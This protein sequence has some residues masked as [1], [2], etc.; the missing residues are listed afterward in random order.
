MSA[1]AFDSLCE[2]FGIARSYTDIWGRARA[3]PEASCRA[4]LRAFGVEAPEEPAAAAALAALE[5]QDWQRGLPPVRVVAED[6][7]TLTL[8]VTLPAACAGAPLRW[9]LTTEARETRAG[10]IAL[11]ASAAAATREIEGAH[12]IACEIHLPL[13]T[14]CGYHR[15]ALEAPAGARPWRA[16]SWIIVAPAQ[17]YRP[18]ALAGGGRSWGFTAQIYALRSQRNWG[19]G[20]FTDLLR[21]VERA[22]EAGA[23][24]VGVS[25]LHALFPHNPAHA[26]PYSP[27]SRQFLNTLHLDIEAI[28]ELAE[29]AAARERIAAEAFQAR[30]RGLRASE[31]VRYEEVAQLKAEVL[32]ALHAHFRE[33][34]LAAGDARAREFER[35]REQAG[36]ALRDYAVFEALQ[37]HLHA[38]DPAIWGWPVWPEQY[39]RADSE[40]VTA[41]ARDHEAA[42]EARE[43][44]QWQARAQL[45]R[46]GRRAAELGLA[47]G[48][49]Q[50]L[51]VGVDAAGAET[52][53]ES[54]Q[55]ASGVRLG[56]PPDE[57]NL[58]GQEWGL[59]P[60]RPDR[61]EESGYAPFVRTLRAVMQAAGAIR[62]DH[63]LGLARQFWVPAGASPAEGTYVRFPL[64]DLL[65]VLALESQRHQ[66]LVVGEDLGTVPETIRAGMA[67]FDILSYRL[68]YFSK[69]EDGAFLAPGDYPERALVCA[70]TH[71]LPTLAGYWAGTDIELRRSLGLFPDPGEHENQVVG[72]AE[73]RARLLLALQREGLLPAD[74]EPDVLHFPEMTPALAAAIHRYLARS[75]CRVLTIQLEDLLG[76]RDQVNLPG[77]VDAYPNWRLKLPLDLEA[78][79]EAE[80]VHTLLA[81][82]RAERGSA[83]AAPPPEPAPAAPPRAVIPRATYRLQLHAGF[84]FEAARALVPYL[85]AL[86]VSHLYSSPCL[87]ARPGSR[88]GYDICD[89]ASLNAELGGN[90]GFD[91][92]AEAVTGRGMGLVLDLVPNHMGVMGAD[93]AWWLDVLE[94]GPASRYAEYFDIDWSPLKDELRGKVLVPVLGRLYGEVLDAGELALRL[95][96]GTGTLSVDYYE[97]RFPVDPRSYPVVLDRHIHL[98]EA[99]LGP[100]HPTLLAFQSLLTAFANLPPREATGETAVAERARDAV[101]HKG[102]LAAL[103][104]EQPDV[105]AYLDDCLRQVNGGPDYP[106]DHALLHLLLEQQAYRLAYWRVAADAINYR[107]FFDIND[108]AALRMEREAVFEDTHALVLRLIAEGKVAGLR[109]DHPDGLYDPKAYCAGVQARVAA[110]AGTDAKDA[111]APSIYLVVEKILARDEALPAN[112][113]VHGTTGYEF[114]ATAGGVLLDPRGAAPLAETY[115]RFTGAREALPAVEH[116][117]RHQIMDEALSAELNVLAREL[118]RIAEAD[119][120]TRD[121]TEP[122][123]RKALA[124]V[125]AC[126]PVYRTYL[127]GETLSESDEACID[128]ALATARRQA[129]SQEPAVFDFVRDALRGQAAAGRGEDERARALRFA[130]RCQQFT[131]PVTAKGVEDTAFYRYHR[132]VSLNE[133]GDDPGRFGATPA[134][135]HAALAARARDWPHGLLLGSSHDSKRSEDL[136]LRLHVLAELPEQWAE[137]VQHWATLNARHKRERDGEPL[138]EPDTEY[139]LYQNLLGVWPLATEPA[140]AAD[141][142]RERLCEYAVKAAREAKQRTAWNQPD[143][144]YEQALQGFLQGILDPSGNAEFLEDLAAFHDRIARPGLLNSLAFNLLKLAAPGVPDTYQGNELWR[145]D[146]VDPDNRRPVDFAHR[147]A[148]LEALQEQC[149]RLGA[150]EV[151]ERLLATPEDGRLK[152]FLIWRALGLRRSAPALFAH[153]DYLPL[154]VTGPRAEHCFAFARRAAGHSLVAA[155][156]RLTARLPGMPETLPLGD[157]VWRHTQIQLPAPHPAT[158]RDALTG[159]ELRP[160]ADGTLPLAEAFAA[161]PGA[162]LHSPT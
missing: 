86:G 117:A 123:L 48:L 141:A 132:L 1:G 37:A 56:A 153:G 33:H 62:I 82:L 112:W 21:L 34:H 129:R 36:P 46:V 95:D 52:W 47:V 84:G 107:R 12:W 140:A 2:R 27:S 9:Q 69:D 148:L 50:D 65:G 57:F 29:C 41:F 136:R 11:A 96:A 54:E 24:I 17:C 26:S 90:A 75:P 31:Q 144:G 152:L 70:T 162:L 143:A 124:E 101:L 130:M 115:A 127:D 77:T 159:A 98:L 111:G 4:L 102:R 119:P 35:F 146:L 80:R 122:A 5:D 109:I 106:A 32:A 113:P 108:L 55:F 16:E 6:S 151:A 118:S 40:A 142:V 139:A 134:A 83:V 78:W 103:A 88:H 73:D 59:P 154:E 10:E 149:H 25:P 145:F 138:P 13:E 99:R 121:L 49:Y 76:Q 158:L 135:L 3:V 15:L 8:P 7:E 23:G 71:D 89:H 51:A 39:R 63:V 125:V 160:S 114:A 87:Q 22:A 157:R 44:A 120:R 81:A 66:C 105:R 161:F 67:A 94:H 116:Q 128:R 147:Q 30:L 72:R 64:D 45:D 43:Y 131:A 28:P 97:H 137:R 79:A 74:T 60:W 150:A 104:A 58:E 110:L 61:L 93:N 126:F 19:I 100:E 133:V 68:L 20:D 14:P 38:Q 85:D 42:I 18:P 91:R 53:A 155:V 92:L 156:P